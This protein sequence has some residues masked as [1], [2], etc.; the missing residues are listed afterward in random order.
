MGSKS[1]IQTGIY[2]LNLDLIS[3]KTGLVDHKEICNKVIEFYN[4]G[5]KKKFEERKTV[6]GLELN[7][8]DI[9]IYSGVFS[10]EATWYKFLSTLMTDDLK[11]NLKTNNIPSFVCFFSDGKNIF[12]VTGG[13][14]HHII[15]PFVVDD[16]GLNILEKLISSSSKSVK[17]VQ[18]RILTGQIIANTRFFRDDQRIT[19]EDN[20]GSVYKVIR[21]ELD[22][23]V[24]QKQLGFNEKDIKKN[25]TCEAKSSF[26]LKK[27]L[28]PYEITLI[29]KKLS[30]ILRMKSTIDLS[31][32]KSL[33]KNGKRGKELRDSLNEHIGEELFKKYCNIENANDPFNEFDLCHKDY[34]KYLCAN[35]YK[36]TIGRSFEAIID[37]VSLT[38]P[39]EIF[40][41]LK[42]SSQYSDI[43]KESFLRLIKNINITSFDYD[44]KV[45]T[46]GSLTS[47]IHGEFEFKKQTYFLID[48][49]WYIVKRN[50]IDNLN[51]GIRTLLDTH[52]DN[53]VIGVPWNI[54]KHKK[55]K[56]FN[57]SFYRNANFIV[58]DRLIVE[59]IELCD[60]IKV[61]EDSIQIIH[62]KKGFNNSIRE[63][64][65]QIQVSA[66]RLHEDLIKTKK[67]EFLKKVYEKAVRV[68]KGEDEYFRKFSDW[69]SRYS[70][71]DFID[72]FR[73]KKRIEF[74]LAFVDEASTIR[75]ITDIESFES[76]IAKF[77]IFQLNQEV[78][79]YDF[80]LKICQICKSDLDE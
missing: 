18:E 62:V 3:Q 58:L 60:L 37:E 14:G 22:Q 72:L 27:I 61:N 51:S 26:L 48:G 21:A 78:K 30:T 46:V 74:C 40:K 16:F 47:H 77:S 76:N 69:L 43:D 59:N 13:Y 31:Q 2:L 17:S 33:S 7:N 10:R 70:E 8:F 45:C 50:F 53:S 73:S 80:D 19:E 28:D 44:G 75:S 42:V 66:R 41:L 56:D 24:L 38:R 64:S 67:G 9:Y 32:I 12:A 68:S 39:I 71:S 6:S 1:G 49:L 23:G 29:L 52:L 35:E 5:E 63:L 15:Q 25:L 55:E 34:E 4:K 20:F 54:L 65:S 11:Y 36:I 79:K 57:I